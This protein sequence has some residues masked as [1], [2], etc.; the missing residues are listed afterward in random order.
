M[1]FEGFTVLFR[2]FGFRLRSSGISALELSEVEAFGSRS[3]RLAGGSGFRVYMPKP[4][5]L[6]P[7]PRD[8]GEEVELSTGD[9]LGI[10]VKHSEP[11]FLGFKTNTRITL[12]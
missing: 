6:N 3:L 1:E 11:C 10:A 5:I 7:K 2:V 8:S 4:E 12:L 9:F